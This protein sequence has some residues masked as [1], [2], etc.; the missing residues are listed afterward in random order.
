MLSWR[1]G[2]FAPAAP[3][4]DLAVEHDS[5]PAQRRSV[6]ANTSVESVGVYLPEREVT[7][8]EVVRGCRRRVLLPLERL[9][10]IRSRRM[11]GETEFS[12]DLARNA[13]AKCL[14]ASRHGAA[15]IDLIIAANIS[16]QDSPL[17]YNVEPT[18]AAVLRRQFGLHHALAFDLSNACAGVFTAIMVVDE[19]IRRGDVRRALVVSGEYITHLTATAQRELDGVHDQRL[20][21]L[22]LGDAG[23]CLLLEQGAGFD[24]I[25]ICTVPE[26]AE[27][28]IAHSAESHGAIMFTDS[29]RL[30]RAGIAEAVKQYGDVVAAGRVATDPRYFIP[31]QTSSNSIKEATRATN[32]RLGRKVCHSDNTVDN[33]RHRGNTATTSHWVA[34]NDLIEASAV[35]PGDRVLFSITASGITVGVAQYRVEEFAARKA[36]GRPA[37]PPAP[38]PAPQ[39]G[40]RG[41]YRAVP[42]GERVRVDSA[43]TCTPDSDAE[44][45]N[46]KLAARAVQR[47]VAAGT[48][49]DGHLGLLLYSGVYR[50]AFIS[51]PALATM[52][53]KELGI[54]GSRLDNNPRPFLAFDVMNG[55]PGVLMA[56][57]VAG[58]LLL[59]RDGVAVVAASEFTE[60]PVDGQRPLGLASAGSALVLERSSGRSGFRS[61]FVDTH[62]EYLDWYHAYAYTDD[63]GPPRLRVDRDERFTERLPEAV[64]GSVAELLRRESLSLDDFAV[65]FPPQF[66]PEFLDRLAAVLGVEHSR[67]VS[68]GGGNLFTSAAAAG[69]EA[70]RERTFAPGSLGLFLTAGAGIEVACA[71]YEF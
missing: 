60:T 62:A 25:E 38:A 3:A 22:T 27:L 36:N 24:F 11:A 45:G 30:A 70:A 59:S 53:A 50:E 52:V 37:S 20:A 6:T 8:T 58:R 66:G 13:L 42:P 9:T 56:C 7:T 33:L 40:E 5:A 57:L 10:G 69:W 4:K 32:R 55:P 41:Y 49:P 16:K 71:T 65:I 28:C 12:V 17:I 26:H 64:A 2:G 18:T 39:I 1:N 54:K 47:A 46:V 67:L 44:R 19:L 68:C 15:D 63:S 21:C 35:Q 43:A 61:F 51:E 31:H 48:A 34:V 29:V 14:A 23:V